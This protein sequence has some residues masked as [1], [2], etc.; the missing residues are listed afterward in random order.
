MTRVESRVTS[1]EGRV[2]PEQRRVGRAAARKKEP[3]KVFEVSPVTG[4]EVQLLDG[5]YGPYVTDG[6]TNASL[7]RSL[8]PDEVTFE[9]ALDLLAERAARGPSRRATRKRTTKKKTTKKKTSKKKAAT[10][11]PA[12][13]KAAKKGS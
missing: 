12:K 8:Q 7:P 11:K 2:G 3:L 9:R 1:H 5:R 10:K 13:K 4:K 6:S